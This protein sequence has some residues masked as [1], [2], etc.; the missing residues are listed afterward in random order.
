MA[1]NNN[2]QSNK[3]KPNPSIS[4]KRTRSPCSG[5]Q[6]GNLIAD[7]T[8]SL[9]SG[10]KPEVGA[11]TSQI[12]DRVTDAARNTVQPVSSS[13]SSSIFA[14]DFLTPTTA[15]LQLRMLLMWMLMM[16]LSQLLPLGLPT[17]QRPGPPPPP[18]LTLL[19]TLTLLVLS[20]S[21]NF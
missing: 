7:S 18:P 20:R 6:I 12:G 11:I 16:L 4:E 1:Q 8:N 21:L 17:V 9:M 19:S 3:K 2:N 10:L 15:E 14:P 5:S 13:S